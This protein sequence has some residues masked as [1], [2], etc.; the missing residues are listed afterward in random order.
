LASQPEKQG[1]AQLG[2][3]DDPGRGA[4]GVQRESEHVDRRLEQLG[5]GSL[6]QEVERVV[7]GN[8]APVPV[9]DHGGTG[10]VAA[11]DQFERVGRVAGCEEQFVALAERDVEVGGELEQRLGAR[12]G[13]AGLDEAD[14]ASGRMR[15]ER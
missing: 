2:E 7:R 3:V 14:V 10:F 8:D 13:A 6:A 11:K 12:S 4:V 9:D 1:R 5:G 15:L